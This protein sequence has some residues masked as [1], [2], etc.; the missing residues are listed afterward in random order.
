MNNLLAGNPFGTVNAP[1]GVNAF[2]GGG[3]V[4]GIP[5]FLNIIFQTLILGAGVYAL[6]SFIL[7]GYSFISAGG[8]SKQVASAWAKIWQSVLGLAV[9]AG[10]FVIAG[11]VGQLLFGDYGA[12]IN[13]RLFGI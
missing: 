6:F 12:I 11:I 9:A 7:A 4:T 2:P 13:F 5:V 1:P 3:S 8:D 10:S